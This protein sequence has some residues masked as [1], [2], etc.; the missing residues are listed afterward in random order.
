MLGPPPLV[1]C[2]ARLWGSHRVGG[3]TGLACCCPVW[4]S[5]WGGGVPKGVGHCHPCDPWL[6]KFCEIIHERMVCALN[7]H[8]HCY[9]ASEW[10]AVCG[11]DLHREHLGIALSLVVEVECMKR[12]LPCSLL[13]S[14]WICPV[15]LVRMLWLV[16]PRWI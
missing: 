9:L 1:T 6:L 8:T 2:S 11:D 13:R 3:V 16:S 14:C 12:A 15:L 10:V 5:C 7:E 4:V